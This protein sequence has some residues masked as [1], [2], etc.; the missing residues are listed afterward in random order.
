[1]QAA[2]IIT[3]VG[4]LVF[5]GFTA[6]AVIQQ[7]L[8]PSTATGQILKITSYLD[9][10]LWLNNTGIDWDK[11]EADKSYWSYLNITNSGQLSCTVTL[12]SIGLPLGWTQTWTANNTLVTPNEWANG[13]LTLTTATVEAITYNWNTII[14]ATQT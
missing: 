11:V 3:L 12:H 2:L 9:G 6:A 7:Y 14:R 5:V 8:H 10:D 13:T 4:V 1:M